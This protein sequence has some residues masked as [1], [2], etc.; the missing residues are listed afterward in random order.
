ML[1]VGKSLLHLARRGVH[2]LR[3]RDVELDH[4]HAVWGAAR[5]EEFGGLRSALEASGAQEHMRVV[6][7]CQDALAQGKPLAL[8]G[9]LLCARA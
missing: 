6:V 1:V 2:T 5:G 9:A 4:I 8:V 7:L 3:A